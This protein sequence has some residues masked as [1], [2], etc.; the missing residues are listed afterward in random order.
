MPTTTLLETGGLGASLTRFGP[1]R[2]FD[3]TELHALSVT[4]SHQTGARTLQYVLGVAVGPDGQVRR[5]YT[6]KTYAELREFRRN[7]LRVLKTNGLCTCRGDHC[8]FGSLATSHLMNHPLSSFS[9]FGFQ[10]AGT[11]VSR[12][13]NVSAFL[14]DLMRGLRTVDAT[15]WSNDCLFLQMI[16]SFF[17]T[18]REHA[19]R[20]KMGLREHLHMNLKGWHH[21]RMKN[22]GIGI[23]YD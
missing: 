22:Y 3:A 23:S 4:F 20:T 21:D 11:L 8:T 15:A 17:D 14:D 13:S 19:G 2:P 9:L 16:A 6:A 1:S 10:L 12:L 5:H 18:A 7:L